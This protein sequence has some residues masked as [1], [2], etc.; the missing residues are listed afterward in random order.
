M[1]SLYVRDIACNTHLSHQSFEFLMNYVFIF[2]ANLVSQ[3]KKELASAS[4]FYSYRSSTKYICS[5]I[6]NAL[7]TSFDF[8]RASEKIALL[9]VVIVYADHRNVSCWI[10]Y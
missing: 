8:C 5:S 9:W 1:S 3:W 2:I 7:H 10:Y 6:Y 4:E